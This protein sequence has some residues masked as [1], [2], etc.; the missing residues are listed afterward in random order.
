MPAVT[1]FKQSVLSCVRY[2]TLERELGRLKMVE[3]ARQEAAVSYVK[4]IPNSETYAEY[5]IPEIKRRAVG[6]KMY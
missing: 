4:Q 2:R 1:A 5:K 3:E 6:N